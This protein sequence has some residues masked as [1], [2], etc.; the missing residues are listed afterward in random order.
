L[1]SALWA[2]DG[3]NNMPMAAGEVI[4]PKRNI[5]LALSVGMT[6]V[7]LIYLLTNFSYFYALPLSEAMSG[8]STLYP[9]ASPIAALAAASVFGVAAAGLFSFGFALSGIGGLNGAVLANA[10]VP[11]AMARDRLF[12][13]FLGKLSS[14]SVPVAAIASQALV[15]VVMALSGTFDQLSNCVVITEWIFYALAIGSL[16]ALRKMKEKSPYEAP[17]FPVLPIL[18]I[19]AA[20]LLIGN[21]LVSL[22]GPSLVGVGFTLAGLPVYYWIKKTQKS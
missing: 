3:W 11:Y 19:S 8:N 6:G 17:F 4:N 9:D 1:I 10:R 5:P 12:F 15:S 18:F 14:S 16:F 13:S 21:S 7:I 2:Y 22:P 20:F